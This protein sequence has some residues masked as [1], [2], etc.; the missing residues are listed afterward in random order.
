MERKRSAYD[1][2][3]ILRGQFRVAGVERIDGH[4]SGVSGSVS[5]NASNVG[6]DSGF[7]VYMGML[8]D[9]RFFEESIPGKVLHGPLDRKIVSRLHEGDREIQEE[10]L[11]LAGWSGVRGGMHDVHCE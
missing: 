5:W 3:V 9:G 11:R 4:E 8:F 6:T 7:R 10:F 2:D 1:P